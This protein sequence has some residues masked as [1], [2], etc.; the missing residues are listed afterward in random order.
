MFMMGA[1][2]TEGLDCASCSGHGNFP[3][4]S[5]VGANPAAIYLACS[6]QSGNKMARQSPEASAAQ[7]QRLLLVGSLRYF[8]RSR[9]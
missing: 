9:R 5:C 2:Y 7:R 8:D 6:R 1:L 3:V 4:Y